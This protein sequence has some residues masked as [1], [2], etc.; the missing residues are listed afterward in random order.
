MPSRAC[1]SP[2]VPAWR[3]SNST[4]KRWPSCCRP[5]PA[6]NSRELAWQGEDDWQRRGGPAQDIQRLLAEL[7]DDA[8]AG[9]FRR[10]PA[11]KE[12]GEILRVAPEKIDPNRSIYDMGLDSLMGV[13]LVLALE[14]R[15]GVRLPV[16][17]LS[18]S[19]TLAKLAERVIQQLRDNEHDGESAAQKDMLAQTEQVA[20]QQGAELSAES[21]ASLAAD[22]CSA[23]PDTT[24]RM[25]N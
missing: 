14:A 23:A 2:T 7:P 21:I 16:M 13:E 15:F 20:M 9:R 10:Y 19:P 24:S 8:T 1:C 11:R 25:I 5:R 17:A 22:V 18:Q 4:G 6:R 3:Y 12:I